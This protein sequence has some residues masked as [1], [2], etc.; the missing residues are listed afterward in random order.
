MLHLNYESQYHAV[1]IC[2]QHSCSNGVLIFP[3]RFSFPFRPMHPCGRSILAIFLAVFV[4]L[5]QQG[6]SLHALSHAT[7][8]VAASKQASPGKQSPDSHDICE[9]CLAFAAASAALVGSMSFS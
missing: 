9:L 6:A 5:A 7:Q 1:T 8:D 2:W 3:D 4:L